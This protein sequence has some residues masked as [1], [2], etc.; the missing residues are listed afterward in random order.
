MFSAITGHEFPKLLLQKQIKQN[1]LPHALLFT[2]IAGIGKSLVAK[3]LAAYLLSTPLEKIE[4]HPDF[5]LLRPESK[6]GVHTMEG[7]AELQRRVECTSFSGAGRILV[8]EEAERMSPP[9]S[10]ALLKTLEEPTEGTVFILLSSRPEELLPTLL[11]RLAKVRFSPL[12]SDEVTEVL[13]KLG[14]A[15]E[16]A[17]FA[18]GSVGK[19][20]AHAQGNSLEALLSPLAT[21]ALSWIETQARLKELDAKVEEADPAL[22]GRLV[23]GIFALLSTWARDEV[24]KKLNSTLSEQRA[25]ESAWRETEKRLLEAKS[26]FSRGIRLSTCLGHVTAP[27]CD[28]ERPHRRAP[29]GAL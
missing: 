19:A 21:G 13:K 7:I 1:T 11:S 3:S 10:H 25:Q 16:T 14:A 24:V 28:K 27:C 15:P 2:G 18:E 22:R 29:Q 26:A 12:S 4:R 23:D 5:F 8:I 20:L 17:R 9:S 6:S